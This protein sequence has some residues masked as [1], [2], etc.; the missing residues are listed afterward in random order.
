MRHGS[1]R[2]RVAYTAMP[3]A[4]HR[5]ARDSHLAQLEKDQG[6]KSVLFTTAQVMNAGEG[7]VEVIDTPATLGPAIA[8]YQA[9]Y[10]ELDAFFGGPA[11]TA[12]TNTDRYMFR[13]CAEWLL[14]EAKEAARLLKAGKPLPESGD[15]SAQSLIKKY[16][17]LVERSN[18]ITWK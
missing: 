11:L 15:G 7:M 17:D 12:S 6:R 10:D 13:Q 16:D 1:G 3:D 18:Q 5:A 14:V 4:R 8:K 2:G 9:A